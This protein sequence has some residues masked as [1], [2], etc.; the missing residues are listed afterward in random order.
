MQHAVNDVVKD[1]TGVITVTPP[2]P[3]GPGEM[4]STTLGRQTQIQTLIGPRL[5][6]STCHH[7]NTERHLIRLVPGALFVLS[8][9]PPS[10]MTPPPLPRRKQP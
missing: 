7:T 5:K 6:T 2:Q 4:K 9:P 8:T 1:P 10:V 3:V